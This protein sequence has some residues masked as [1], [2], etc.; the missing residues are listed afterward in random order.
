MEFNGFAQGVPCWIDASCPDVDAAAAFYTALF[1]WEVPEGNPEFGG[2]R[3][4][5]M[6]DRRVAGLMG[7]MEPGPAYW[8]TYIAVDDAD[9][10]SE[11]VKANGGTAM[12]EPMTVGDFGR[13]AVFTDPSGAAFGI[14]QADTHPGCELANEPG[15][16][17]WSELMATDMDGSKK[18]YSAVFGWAWG[19]VEEYAEF[20]IDGRSLGGMMPMPPTM[21]EGM[22]PVWGVYFA[23]EDAEATVAAAVGLGATVFMPPTA[24]EPGTFAVLADPNGAVFNVIALKPADVGS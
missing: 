3:S 15:T 19:G 22:P 12:M 1:G 9:A 23:V 5:T 20:Q 16:F 11:V 14:W 13:M 10:I 18:F 4:A 24:I 8:A 17:C 7:Q 6:R 21:P 2:Y